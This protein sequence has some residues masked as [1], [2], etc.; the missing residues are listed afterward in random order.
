MAAVVL[1]LPP[2]LRAASSNVVMGVVVGIPRRSGIAR[3]QSA[4]AGATDCTAPGTGSSR[5]GCYCCCCMWWRIL[6]PAD[7]IAVVAATIP[8]DTTSWMAPPSRTWSGAHVSTNYI[9]GG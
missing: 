8:V 3:N 6:C 7:L 9:L 4:A 5:H 2:A 1:V